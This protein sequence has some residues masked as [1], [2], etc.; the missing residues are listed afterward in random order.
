MLS[1]NTLSLLFICSDLSM[2]S[3]F[4][5]RLP[6]LYFHDA[7]GGSGDLADS[8][9]ILT[10]TSPP[11]VCVSWHILNIWIINAYAEFG[12]LGRFKIL[13]KAPTV[14]DSLL[15]ITKTALKGDKID[16]PMTEGD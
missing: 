2:Y 13:W 4:I 6:Q 16:T 5:L 8:G 10:Q 15:L 1:L 11:R 12:E 7:A 3:T 9:N 14:K